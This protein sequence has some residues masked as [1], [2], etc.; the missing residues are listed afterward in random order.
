[1]NGL[2][3]NELCCLFC[4]PPFPS[5]IVAKLA[6]LPPQATYK[7]VINEDQTATTP[8][9]ENGVPNKTETTPP[10]EQTALAN[11]EKQKAD[12]QDATNVFNN[13]NSSSWAARLRKSSQHLC[14]GLVC[15]K[16]YGLSQQNGAYQQLHTSAKI[17]ML[18][19]A[20]WQY[21]PMELEKLEVFLARTEMGISWNFFHEKC[22]A[23]LV[24]LSGP[25]YPLVRFYASKNLTIAITSIWIN[26][27]LILIDYNCFCF[28]PIESITSLFY[29]VAMFFSIKRRN[30]G[31]QNLRIY[32]S[33]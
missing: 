31:Y 30:L 28:L 21:G 8:P 3:M 19:K 25:I 6:F 10:S 29:M 7:L 20:E 17:V 1:M 24:R 33:I 18:D 14:S 15:S 11:G 27:G 22:F 32:P 13:R 12:A 4:C 23:V 16:T 5:K 9:Q 26:L 2:T